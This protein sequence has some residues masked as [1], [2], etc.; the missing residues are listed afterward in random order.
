MWE[1]PYIYINSSY[2]LAIRDRRK[3]KNRKE[4]FNN[5]VHLPPLAYLFFSTIFDKSHTHIWELVNLMRHFLGIYITNFL[6]MEIASTTYMCKFTLKY[7]K[8][9]RGWCCTTRKAMKRWNMMCLCHILSRQFTWLQILCICMWL[10]V[11]EAHK[12][13]WYMNKL[14]VRAS[15]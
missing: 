7:V 6:E 9:Y 5:N 2:T 3:R 13:L 12:A 14:T 15:S 4:K 10:K 1:N 11:V 8:Y